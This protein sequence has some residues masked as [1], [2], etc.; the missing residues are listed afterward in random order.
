MGRSRNFLSETIDVVGADTDV[1]FSVPHTLGRVPQEAFVIW[2]GPFPMI[3]Y[4][5]TTAWTATEIYMKASIG[6]GSCTILLI[7]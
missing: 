6:Y 2:R 4:R 7:A 1:E 5:G 3:F